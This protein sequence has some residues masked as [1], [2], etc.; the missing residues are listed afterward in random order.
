MFEEGP[1]CLRDWLFY[2]TA[3]AGRTKDISSCEPC[4]AHFFEI[5][6]TLTV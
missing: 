5:N 6:V 4:L 2:V 3:S 1:V